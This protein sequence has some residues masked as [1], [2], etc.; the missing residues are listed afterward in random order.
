MTSDV[1][2][3]GAG[4]YMLGT[5]PPETN[6]IELR[7]TTTAQQVS[8]TPTSGKKIRVHTIHMSCTIGVALSATL[9]GSVSFGTG[10]VSNPSK[11]LQSERHM[12][13]DDTHT[14][15]SPILNVVGAVNE[16]VTLTNVTFSAGSIT[17]RA[18]IYYTEV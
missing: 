4:N 15:W 1:Y 9:R 3:C 6:H 16:T 7:V 13:G 5:V 10:G 17:M 18:I 2:E 8:L 14:E 12:K 11:V